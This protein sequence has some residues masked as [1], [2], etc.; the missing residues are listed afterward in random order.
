MQLDSCQAA[1]QLSIS[2]AEAIAAVAG[3]HDRVMAAAACWSCVAADSHAVH[4]VSPPHSPTLSA[5]AAH[6]MA[7]LLMSV[8]QAP[9]PKASA[10][11]AV[12]VQLE[13]DTCTRRTANTVCYI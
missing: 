2:A 3:C 9:P 12:N 11:F 10:A 1:A 6:L 5:A 8:R 13:R 7:M 4:H